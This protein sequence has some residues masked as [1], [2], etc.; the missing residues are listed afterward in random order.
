MTNLSDDHPAP[1]TR[2]P[3]KKG[4][5]QAILAVQQE[6]GVLVKT[7]RNRFAH[8]DFVPIDTY[9][10]QVAPLAAK[11]G[12]SWKVNLLNAKRFDGDLYFDVVV[13]LIFRDSRGEEWEYPGYAQ[14]AIF[15]QYIGPQTTGSASSYANKA[16][17][18]DLFKIPATGEPDPDALPQPPRVRSRPVP[19][20]EVKAG[21][22]LPPVEHD[23]YGAHLVDPPK[24]PPFDPA[25]FEREMVGFASESRSQTELERH[26]LERR[27]VLIEMEV[28]DPERYARIKAAFAGRK[29]VLLKQAKAAAPQTEAPVKPRPVP[30]EVSD[31]APGMASRLRR[32]MRPISEVRPGR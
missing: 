8:Y 14:M 31:T 3:L 2:R 23:G 11:H 1:K 9:Y 30:P 26:W 29:D 7:D 27:P 5:V 10:E 20:R 4:V 24:D 16:F 22:D 19:M 21:A 15:H 18:R 17:M 12:L 25:R 13:D 28:K 6:V 32:V